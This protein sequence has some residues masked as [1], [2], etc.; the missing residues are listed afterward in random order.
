MIPDCT[1]HGTWVRSR[2]HDGF[3]RIC[4]QINGR[5]SPDSVEF[6][7]MWNGPDPDM[8]TKGPTG[9]YHSP[10]DLD[11]RPYKPKPWIDNP[12][13]VIIHRLWAQDT[14]RILNGD[15]RRSEEMS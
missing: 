11:V 14:E 10:E 9:S 7:I 3:G 4:W 8:G 15:V 13:R 12:P 5:M 1:V 6:F 2:V